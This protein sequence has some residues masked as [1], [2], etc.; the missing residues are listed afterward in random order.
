MIGHEEG[1]ELRPLQ[2]LNALLG[3]GE[4]EIHIRPGAGIAPGAGVNARRPHESAEVELT[5]RSHRS[6]LCC[7]GNIVIRGLGPE[8]A[9][10]KA[11]RF[12]E[13]PLRENKFRLS[14]ADGDD[15]GERARPS[16]N[17]MAVIAGHDDPLAVLLADDF[18]DM[19]RPDHDRADAGGSGPSPMRPIARQVK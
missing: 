5:G 9:N 2:R 18:A 8:R 15:A 12:P 4:I 13:R 3:M 1:V 7:G 11:A 6:V 16:A 19:V 14:P 17:R 10:K